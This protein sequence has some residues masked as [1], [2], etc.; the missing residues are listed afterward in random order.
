MP[1][2]KKR[3]PYIK[4]IIAL[5]VLTSGIYFWLR[6][7][8][9]FPKRDVS[10][11][12]FTPSELFYYDGKDGHPAYFAY[13]G[14]VYDVTGSRSWVEGKHLGGHLAGTD[15]SRQLLPA[16]HGEEVFSKFKVV[17]HLIGKLDVRTEAVFIVAIASTL[18]TILLT[19]IFIKKVI[20]KSS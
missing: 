13:Q 1:K 5:L 12:I 18:S 14:K 4:T 7:P 11:K 15:L 3:F 19:S 8:Y 9:Y 16:P 20:S 2:N 6:K 10:V 17:G